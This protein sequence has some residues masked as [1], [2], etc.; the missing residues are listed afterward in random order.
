MLARESDGSGE[1]LFADLTAQR[2]VQLLQERVPPVFR[3][4]EVHG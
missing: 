2:G 3:E 4:A 1:G